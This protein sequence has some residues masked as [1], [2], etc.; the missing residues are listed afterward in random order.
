M[1]TS[2]LYKT[3]D[4]ANNHYD[5]S[6]YDIVSFDIFDTLLYR[7]FLSGKEL[8]YYLEAKHN[9]SGWYDVRKQAKNSLKKSLNSESVPLSVIYK[10]MPAEYTFMKEEE[11]KAELSVIIPNT[12][13][14]SLFEQAKA[15][16]KKIF[17]ISDMHLEHDFLDKLL[18]K[19]GISGY[20]RLYVSS[21]YGLTKRS[22]HLFEKVQS[23]EGIDTPQKWLHIG[24]NLHS[25]VQVP[26]SLGI[27]AWYYP[28]LAGTFL[29]KTEFSFCRMYWNDVLKKDDKRKKFLVSYQLGT[30]ALMDKYGMFQNTDIHDRIFMMSWIFILSFWADFIYDK[31]KQSGLNDI[32]FIARDGYL[33]QKIFEEKYNKNGLF[34]SQYVYANRF[35]IKNI[36]LDYGSKA[37]VASGDIESAINFYVQQYP[38]LKKEFPIDDISDEDLLK[39]FNQKYELLQ[40]YSHKLD[41]FYQNYM[42]DLGLFNKDIALVDTSTIRFTAQ[43]FLKRYTKSVVGFYMSCPQNNDVS[44]RYPCNKKAKFRVI[45][46][47][48]SSPENPIVFINRK[49]D[50]SYIPIT[51]EGTIEN[52][53]H[54]IIQNGVVKLVDFCR[55][56]H[57][58][59]LDYNVICLNE[60]QEIYHYFLLSLKRKDF[61]LLS[62]LKNCR[63]ISHKAAHHENTWPVYYSNFLTVYQRR[64]SYC[65]FLCGIKFKIPRIFR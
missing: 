12:E 25:D 47:Y 65:I 56:F 35:L 45:E 36:T 2:T 64:S 11:E 24:D 26:L 34:N 10:N 7:P 41:A 3:L 49:N 42:K 43:D 59:C 14:I 28:N 61:Q 53:K 20:D 9:V 22:G 31:I 38:E 63:S 18:Q 44:I 8:L 60:F 62:E 17:I 16:K 37:R 30:M 39:L 55:H 40:S 5:F 54:S 32:A 46:S 23:E 21:E 15:Q 4:L 27:N 6:D 58:E 19:N 48:I 50:G 29:N 51:K 57:T 33:I 52:K 13:M 1:G